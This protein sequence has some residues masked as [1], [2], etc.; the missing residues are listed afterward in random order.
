VLRGAALELTPIGA[1]ARM[2]LAPN[3]LGLAAAP[4]TG[5]PVM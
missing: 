1:V 2:R 5:E 4:A 3:G